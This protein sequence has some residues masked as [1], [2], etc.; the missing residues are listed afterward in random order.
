LAISI[1][2]RIFV[3]S[4]SI[5]EKYFSYVSKQELKIFKGRDYKLIPA[6]KVKIKIDETT[7]S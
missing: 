4:T 3:A 2:L 1:E 5:T 7:F 6:T